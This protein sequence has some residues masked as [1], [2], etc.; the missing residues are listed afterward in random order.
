M[1]TREQKNSLLVERVSSLDT[2]SFRMMRT[3]GL[4]TMVSDDSNMMAIGLGGFVGLVR[5]YPRRNDLIEYSPL[6][7]GDYW[8]YS[9]ACVLWNVSSNKVIS[10]YDYLSFPLLFRWCE[11]KKQKVQPIRVQS[12]QAVPKREKKITLTSIQIDKE[13]RLDRPTL[14][15]DQS[16]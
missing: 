11:K 2:F 3:A 12:R 15:I 7:L 16:N 1:K 13:I 10:E 5:F 6:I 9:L 4:R 8:L 14:S